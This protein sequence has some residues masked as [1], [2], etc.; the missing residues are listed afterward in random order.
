MRGNRRESWL[1]ASPDSTDLPGATQPSALWKQGTTSES[2]GA[3][4]LVGGS[5]CLSDTGGHGLL[6][7][8]RADSEYVAVLGSAFADETAK[9]LAGTASRDTCDL[10]NCV[11]HT[12]NL[13]GGLAF[14]YRR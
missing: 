14:R 2:I 11:E 9:T 8:G 10:G 7:R 1:A 5:L 4:L 6:C 12:T 13:F 3:L